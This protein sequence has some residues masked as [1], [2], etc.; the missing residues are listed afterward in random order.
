MALKKQEN[1]LYEDAIEELET[2]ISMLENG[3]LSLNDAL[4]HFE[5]GIYLSRSSHE[6]LQTA[7]QQVNILMQKCSSVALQEFNQ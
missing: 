2:I 3:N 1:M 5:R 7:Q 4:K 6:K